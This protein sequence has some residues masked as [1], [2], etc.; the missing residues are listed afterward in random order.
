MERG[1]RCH[2]QTRLVDNLRFREIS[3]LERPSGLGHWY[4]AYQFEA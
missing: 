1:P 4:L 2:F 3:N